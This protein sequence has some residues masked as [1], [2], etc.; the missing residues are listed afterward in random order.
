ML[1]LD[2]E[3]EASLGIDSIKQVEILSAFRERRPDLPELPPPQLAA[4]RTRGAIAAC[5]DG[6]DETTPT[7][8]TMAAMRSQKVRSTIRFGGTPTRR[9]SREAMETPTR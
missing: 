4:P 5:A 7:A 6:A 3:I 2:M 8:A 9:P 1:D